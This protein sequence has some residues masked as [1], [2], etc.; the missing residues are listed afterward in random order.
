MFVP[1]LFYVV[2]CFVRVGSEAEM[3]VCLSFAFVLDSEKVKTLR[4]LRLIVKP[5]DG[6][7][8]GARQRRS[9]GLDG[10]PAHLLM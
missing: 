2:S 1:K 3:L 10:A 7:G 5:G 8:A 9:W 4:W 6:G